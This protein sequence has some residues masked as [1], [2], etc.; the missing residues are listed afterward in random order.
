MVENTRFLL[1]RLGL[2]SG[3]FAVSFREGIPWEWNDRQCADEVNISELS[4]VFFV[5][6][7]IFLER[8]F[9][10]TRSQIL[11]EVVNGLLK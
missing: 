3:A 5:L 6:A 2:V 9:D 4:C 8:V 10:V 7:D 11:E 1:G